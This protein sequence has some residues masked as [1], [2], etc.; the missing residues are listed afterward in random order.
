MFSTVTLTPFMWGKTKQ[1]G[2]K[3]Q[4]KSLIIQN[5]MVTCL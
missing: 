1:E 2:K 5:N 3:Q 4:L